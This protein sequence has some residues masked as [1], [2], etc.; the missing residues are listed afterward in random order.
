MSGIDLNNENESSQGGRQYLSFLLGNE[1][2]GVD[3]MRAQEV[4]G[5][6]AIDHV[7]ETLPYMKGV[8][9]LRGKIA[10]IVDL[11]IKFGMEW[12]EY[13]DD[14]TIIITEMHGEMV[15]FIVD[16]VMDVIQ[17][18]KE[19]IQNTPHFTAKMEKDAVNGIGKVNDKIIILLD[20]DKVF[21]KDEMK[22]LT[23]GKEE[24]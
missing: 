12:K 15:G 8:I 10:P 1:L 14:T 7:P 24:V 11:R 6:T 2:Y 21:T 22:G 20:I 17:I 3:V 5:I 16:S 9:D 4:L 19:D 18:A 23:P 13:D